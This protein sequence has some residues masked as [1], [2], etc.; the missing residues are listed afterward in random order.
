MKKNYYL[1]TDHHHG[2]GHPPV[3][4][5]DYRREKGSP[6]IRATPFTLR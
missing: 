4:G 3:C 2:P 5:A 6:V 1:L